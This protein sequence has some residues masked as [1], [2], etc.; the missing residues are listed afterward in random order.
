VLHLHLSDDQRCAV[1]ST[2]FPLLTANL[3]GDMGGSYTPYDV[4][5]IIQYA[6]ARGILIIPE[7]S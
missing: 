1:D 3:T 2:T 5:E 4:T 6:T 7:V